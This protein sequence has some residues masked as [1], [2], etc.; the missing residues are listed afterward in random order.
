MAPASSPFASPDFAFAFRELMVEALTDELRTTSKVL[1]AVPD[2]GQ[3]YRPDP[4]SRSTWEL[5]WHIAADV[6]FIEGIAK[7]EFQLNPDRLNPNPCKTGAELAE[8]YAQ[9]YRQA[10]EQVRSLTAEE[11]TVPL[12][13]GGVA[14]EAGITFPAFLYL[15]WVHLHTVHHR[16]QL[17]AYLRPA[18]AKVPAIYG[19]S[20]DDPGR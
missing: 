17:T 8:W 18:G 5:A 20:A 4:K 13:L 14:A 7:K 9:R 15:L 10:L 6:W 11:L 12:T 3:S 19:P 16:G 1:A 2:Q